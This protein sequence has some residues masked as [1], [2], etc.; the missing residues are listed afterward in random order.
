LIPSVPKKA[1]PGI[2]TLVDGDEIQFGGGLDSM[3]LNKGPNSKI[4]NLRLAV[5]RVL[6]MSGAAD[7]ILKWKDE[8][9]DDGL[10]RLQIPSDEFCDILSARLR[11]SGRAVV[12]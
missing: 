1:G 4:C 9:D 2:I 12:A 3:Q 7:I 10:S 5:A 6:K 11:L 8:A